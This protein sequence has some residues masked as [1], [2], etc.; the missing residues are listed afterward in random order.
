[1]DWPLRSVNSFRVSHSAPSILFC[2]A[3]QQLFPDTSCGNA[4]P[5]A[6]PWY[7]RKIAHHDNLVLCRLP[8]AQ[9]RNCAV[10]AVVAVN[11]FKTSWVDIEF[12]ERRLLLIKKVQLL[13]P[14]L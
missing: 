13:D 8:F 4:Q 3:V 2:I 5:I 11:P 1:M 12:V 9:K 7:G 14:S 6:H 10:L